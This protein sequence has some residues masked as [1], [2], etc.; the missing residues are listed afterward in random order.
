MV[1]LQASASSREKVTVLD[2][3]RRGACSPC[4][5]IVCFGPWGERVAEEL[6][7]L[8]LSEWVIGLARAPVEPLGLG[9]ALGGAR[10][11]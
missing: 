5:R 11:T 1:D 10:L 8:P 6:Q 7:A 3:Q 9:P 4:T 2:V